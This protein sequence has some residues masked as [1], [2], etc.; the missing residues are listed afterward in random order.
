M[1]SVYS[2]ARKNLEEWDLPEEFSKFF[3]FA[4]VDVVQNA[5]IVLLAHDGKLAIGPTDDSGRASFCKVRFFDIYVLLNRQLT[6]TLPRSKS[7]N[8]AH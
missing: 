8:R 2:S 3:N 4:A 6:K 1:Q 7:Q 5:L